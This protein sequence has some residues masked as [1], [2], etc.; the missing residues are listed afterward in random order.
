MVKNKV[1]YQLNLFWLLLSLFFLSMGVFSLYYSI[2]LVVALFYTPWVE[3]FLAL[4]LMIFGTVFTLYTF[5]RFVHFRI[6]FREESIFVPSDWQ[7]PEYRIQYK[8]IIRYDEIE[9]IHMIRSTMNSLN[10]PI[11]GLLLS[12]N[13][14]KP[15][16]EFTT[17][18]GKKKRIFISYFTRRQRIKVIDEVKRRMLLVGNNRPINDTISIVNDLPSGGFIIY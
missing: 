9:E 1:V 2:Q 5:V 15:Y 8:T 13:V 4:A 17:K 12:S 7:S 18:E 6:V 16:I 3:V 11:T 14:L 10:K